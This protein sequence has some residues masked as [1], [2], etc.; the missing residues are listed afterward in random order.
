MESLGVYS[1]GVYTW[2]LEAL[3]Q[4]ISDLELHLPVWESTLG[5]YSGSL[6][7]LGQPILDLKLHLP[8]P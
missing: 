4:P 3:G 6:E 5:V 8:V 1:L 2:S 7:A